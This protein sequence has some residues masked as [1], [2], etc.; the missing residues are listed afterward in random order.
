MSSSSRGS[1]TLRSVLS[2]KYI[3]MP[4]SCAVC[5]SIGASHARRWKTLLPERDTLPDQLYQLRRRASARDA[6]PRDR[7]PRASTLP[8][9]PLPKQPPAQPPAPPRPHH[10]QRLP[11]PPPPTTFAPGSSSRAR[12]SSRASCTPLRTPSSSTRSVLRSASTR[13][14][15]RPSTTSPTPRA[16]STGI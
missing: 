8:P 11:R 7:T 9:R 3:S 5:R 16:A 10:N 2:C 6:P 4:L 13:R 12:L 15:S 1:R 14:S